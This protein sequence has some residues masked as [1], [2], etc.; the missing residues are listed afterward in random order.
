MPELLT[1]NSCIKD[2]K[3]ISTESSLVFDD[4]I[5][6]GTEPNWTELSGLTPN[7]T[8]FRNGVNV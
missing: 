7:L 4:P 6:Q 5:G 8:M 3:R 2:W 1:R